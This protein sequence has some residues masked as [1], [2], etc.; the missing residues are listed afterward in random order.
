[1]AIQMFHPGRAGKTMPCSHCR[2]EF[3]VLFSCNG[4]SQPVC[5]RCGLLKQPGKT[6]LLA[7]VDNVNVPRPINPQREIGIN[8]WLDTDDPQEKIFC[9]TCR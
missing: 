3:K 5:M 1:M 2:G 7:F 6:Q 9:P 8:E 4:C